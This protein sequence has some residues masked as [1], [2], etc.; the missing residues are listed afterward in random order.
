MSYYRARRRQDDVHAHVDVFVPDPIV[1]SAAVQ[2]SV[3]RNFP[4]ANN[5]RRSSPTDVSRST[6]KRCAARTVLRCMY[7]KYLYS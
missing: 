5:R 7:H 2:Q 6:A 4:Y 1:S 3:W